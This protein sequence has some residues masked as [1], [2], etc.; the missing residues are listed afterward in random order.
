MPV[1]LNLPSFNIGGFKDT[2]AD[3]KEIITKT[4]GDGDVLQIVQEK[5]LGSAFVLELFI[6][7]NI[8]YQQAVAICKQQFRGSSSGEDQETVLSNLVEI[9]VNQLRRLPPKIVADPLVGRPWFG[10]N[11]GDEDHLAS[12]LKDKE[13]LAEF[14]VVAFFLNSDTR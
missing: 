8:S 1:A 14:V 2:L 10:I 5:K 4:R 13:E 7:Q 11:H 3:W 9:I 12:V 6:G